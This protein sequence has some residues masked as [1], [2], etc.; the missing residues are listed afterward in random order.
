MSESREDRI[1]RLL[2]EGLDLYGMDEISGA[3]VTWQKVLELEPDNAA[4]LDYIR[5]ADRR[6]LPRPPKSENMASARAAIIQ[7]ARLLM[8]Q[9]DF[10]GAYELLASADG[11]GM[12]DLDFEATHELARSRLYAMYRDRIGDFASVPR[13][14]SEAGSPTKYDLPANAGFV[15]SMVDGATTLAD[16][17][18]LSGMDP[19][20]ALHTLGGLMD[21]GL[22]EMADR[23]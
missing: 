6:K 14:R 15:L 18:S 5:T 12:R 3:I 9:D 17:I 19:F 21:A 2:A 4:A 1:K 23:P 8:R 22:V 13:V 10:A 16:V 20:D 7:E 11:P